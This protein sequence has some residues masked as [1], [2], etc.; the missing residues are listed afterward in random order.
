[1]CAARGSTKVKKREGGCGEEGA[2]EVVNA[3]LIEGH[4]LF[5]PAPLAIKRGVVCCRSALA[6]HDHSVASAVSLLSVSRPTARAAPSTEQHVLGPTMVLVLVFGR[7][8]VKRL[9]GALAL[10]RVVANLP[11][12]SGQLGTRAVAAAALDGHWAALGVA[13]RPFEAPQRR[14]QRVEGALDQ[15]VG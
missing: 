6:T 12:R 8:G 7:R 5:Q 13:R 10:L 14:R 2:H 1:M 9:C 11:E 15:V 3:H 4:R